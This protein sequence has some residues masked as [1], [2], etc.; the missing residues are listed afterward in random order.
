MPLRVIFLGLFYKVVRESLNQRNTQAYS[1][2][3]FWETAPELSKSSKYSKLSPLRQFFLKPQNTFGGIITFKKVNICGSWP[4][5]RANPAGFPPTTAANTPRKVL[6]VVRGKSCIGNTPGSWGEKKSFPVKAEILT[7]DQ[8]QGQKV[9][10]NVNVTYAYM[11]DIEHKWKDSPL[12][13][14][15]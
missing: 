7:E 15:K 6:S 1:Y 8:S 3:L 13:P 11:W 2:S 4:C 9:K 5:W 14:T 12:R 10:V